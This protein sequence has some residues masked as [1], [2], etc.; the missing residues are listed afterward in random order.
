MFRLFP[1]VYLGT[2]TEPQ[3]KCYYFVLLHHHVNFVRARD[4]SPLISS[5]GVEKEFTIGLRQSQLRKY[6]VLS[7]LWLWSNS[8]RKIKEYKIFILSVY[9]LIQYI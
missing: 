9:Y 7:G 6:L 2:S 3:Q 5:C 4:L 1:F 8:Y